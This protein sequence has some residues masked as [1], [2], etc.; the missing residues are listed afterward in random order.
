VHSPFLYE[1]ITFVLDSNRTYYAFIALHRYKQSLLK[2]PAQFN[3]QSLELQRK[4]KR[5]KLSRNIHEM[6]FR[7]IIFSKTR[8]VLEYGTD[9]GFCSLYIKKAGVES[10]TVMHSNE[11]LKKMSS[12]VMARANERAKYISSITE[13]SQPSENERFDLIVIH[14]QQ[15]RDLSTR[16]IDSLTKMTTAECVWYILAPNASNIHHKNWNK[17]VDTLSPNLA[18]DFYTHGMIWPGYAGENQYIY[19]TRRHYL[20][21]LHY[22]QSI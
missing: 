9:F 10:L 4:L 7:H 19:Y 13:L 20:K 21:P 2:P 11:E 6:I 17:L 15:L 14:E 8:R 22:F 5:K 3:Q 18:V 1:Y 16:D 12:R